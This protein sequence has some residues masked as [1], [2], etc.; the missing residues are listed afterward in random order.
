MLSEILYNVPIPVFW[1]DRNSIFVGCNK[2]FLPLCGC[3]S[4]DE[5]VGKNDL[6]LPWA[7]DY[8]KY[9]EDDKHVIT[10]GEDVTRIEKIRL[11]SGKFI[12]SETVKT[13]LIEQRK[14]TGI[15]GVCIDVTLRLENEKLKLKLK[16][17]EEVINERKKFDRFVDDIQ[18]S[19]KVYQSSILTDK[20]SKDMEIPGV[21]YE[22]IDLTKRESE[23]LYLLSLNKPAKE[24]ANIFSI[25]EGEP[26]AP[27]TVHSMI[28]KQ[29]Y[30][31]FNVFNTSD[32][33]K[34]ATMLKLIPFFPESF[35]KLK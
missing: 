1:K 31:K 3:N 25:I 26:V 17:H 35:T 9:H 11:A 4:V 2:L 14:I 15:L 13:P 7:K 12:T 19:I 28:N 20:V 23:I 34:K 16:A 27:A 30:P 29:L 22:K 33:I 32:L 8:L 24:I 21:E 6:E 18:R 5:L 10:T